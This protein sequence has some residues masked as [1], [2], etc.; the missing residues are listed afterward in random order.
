[1]GGRNCYILVFCL[2]ACWGCGKSKSTAELI[3]DLKSSQEKD[4][5]SAVRLLP[6]RKGDAAQIVPALIESLKDKQ[7]DV[8]WSAA[9]GLGNFGEQAREAIPALQAARSDRDARVREAALV[10]LSRIDPAQFPAP[11]IGKPPPGK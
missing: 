3:G 11:S 10:A 8:R 6:Q 4:R 5:I 9:I 1:M 2:L 7:A